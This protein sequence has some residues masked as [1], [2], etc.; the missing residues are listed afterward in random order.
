[1]S[2]EKAQ[3]YTL[4]G[5]IAAAIMILIMVYTIEATSLTPLTSSTANVHVESELQAVGQ[6]ILEV[7]DYNEP[8]YDSRL[9]GDVSVWKGREYTWNGT[10]YM[11][12]GNSTYSQNNLTNNL[13]EILSAIL[14]RQGIAHNVEITFL[15]LNTDN[16]TSS[17]NSRMI[18]NGDPSNNA[19]MVF[20]KLVLHDGDVNNTK[21]P[22]NP[23]GDIDPSTNL[24]N[25][26]D[27]KL[28]LWRM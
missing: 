2:N 16:S 25:I 4:E 22:N 14:V 18:Y 21:F 1:M 28:V 26:V 8:G 12:S 7:L 24:Y 23:I 17:S 3:M 19:V 6:D 13:T 5:M 9:K 20:R 27:V 15:V 10:K 11:E